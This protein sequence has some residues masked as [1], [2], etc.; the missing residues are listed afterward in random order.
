MYAA[1]H[2]IYRVLYSMA[3]LDPD[4]VG[5]AVRKM[6]RERTGGLTHV[7]RRLDEDGILRSDVTVEDATNILWMVCSFES[8]DQLHTERGLSV[9]DTIELT[10]TIAERALYC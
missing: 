1:E 5:G 7:A 8:F 3:Q 4:S 2:D 6:Q 10:I 9:D